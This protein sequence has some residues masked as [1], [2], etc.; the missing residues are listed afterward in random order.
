MT[1]LYWQICG[2]GK[3]DL[4]LLHGWGMN[5]EIWRCVIPRLAPHFRLHLVDLPG[6]GR[7][8]GFDAL[9]LPQMAQVLLKQAPEHAIWLGWSFGG[10]VAS[11]IGLT[12]P[13][14]VKS[15]ITVS[16]SP[17]F[18]VQGAWPGL[19]A[20]T[21]NRYQQQIAEDCIGTLERFFALQT[22]GT[23]NARQDTRTLKQ[24]VLNLP[25]PSMKVIMGGLEILRTAD[26][27]VSMEK[28]QVP[29]LRI[30]GYLDRIVPRETAKLLDEAWPSTQSQT[31][32]KAGHAPFISH[33]EL[34]CDA[35]CHFSGVD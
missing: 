31:I 28:L 18:A 9:S 27:R 25:M 11:Q 35:I 12:T 13:Q 24:A 17:C 6:Y 10:L 32:D 8:R 4:V 21:L 7:S 19:S 20:D 16:S 33:P 29:L 3:Q 15:L 22:L 5:A 14:R 2:E 26:L 1:K 23:E 34:F 30:Y